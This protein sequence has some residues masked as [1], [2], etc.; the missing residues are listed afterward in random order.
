MHG[1]RSG[2]RSAVLL[3]V[4]LDYFGARYFSGAQGRFTSPDSTAYS[5]MSNPQSWNLY[6]YSFNNP[7]R[8][9]D[10]TGHEV[11]A[12]ECKT[13]QD[14]QN[15]LAAVRASLSNGQAAARV[16]IHPIQ[17]GLLGSNRSGNHWR[18]TISVHHQR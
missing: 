16:G 9:T 13:E 3:E 12:A 8:F 14:C 1:T 18:A 5:K 4:G 17:R 15:T 11:Q 10:P 6:A 2:Q 7:L